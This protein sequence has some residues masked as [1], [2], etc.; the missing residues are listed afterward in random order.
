MTWPC[1]FSLHLL[2]TVVAVALLS[3][4]CT[5]VGSESR[6]NLLSNLRGAMNRPVDTEERSRGHSRL[7]EDV[8]QSG[9]L[10]NMT[11]GEVAEAIGRGDPCSR[12][13]KCAELG[14]EG[15]DWFYQ[16]GAMGGVQAPI[17]IVGFDHTGQ[18]VRTW[19]LET[20]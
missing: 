2:A 9:V 15:D 6:D 8:V 13:P 1:G 19:N 7:V 3:G 12:H 18:V 10:Q 17:L 20:Q 14:F 11:R 4:A 16:V 5:H